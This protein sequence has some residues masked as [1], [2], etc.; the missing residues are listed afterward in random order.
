MTP[1]QS[2]AQCCQHSPLTRVEAAPSW[3]GIIFGSHQRLPVVRG[4]RATYRP[5]V[6]L[7]DS[8]AGSDRVLS[9]AGLCVWACVAVVGHAADGRQGLDDSTI[10]DVDTATQQPSP[11]SE[12]RRFLKRSGSESA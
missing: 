6:T 9:S 7:R 8:E 3:R 11:C 12:R 10:D 2:P 4:W 1:E 5:A